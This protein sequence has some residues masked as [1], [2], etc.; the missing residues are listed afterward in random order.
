MTAEPYL[1]Q[2]Y[3]FALPGLYGPGYTPAEPANDR[4]S[5]WYYAR[6]RRAL[7]SP[8]CGACQCNPPVGA[9]FVEGLA[10][11]LQ[12]GESYRVGPF[13]P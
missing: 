3:L 5:A 1:W 10:Q 8:A 4:A 11:I 13:S 9:D 12:D 2:I 6:A 7:R